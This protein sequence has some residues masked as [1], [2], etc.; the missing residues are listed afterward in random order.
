LAILSQSVVK[1]VVDALLKLNSLYL[2]THRRI[3]IDIREIGWES[4]DWIYLAG[5]VAGCCEHIIEPLGF[6]MAG[7]LLN[8]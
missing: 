3:L 5:S 1:T 2:L 7:N 4:V 8:S 6:I